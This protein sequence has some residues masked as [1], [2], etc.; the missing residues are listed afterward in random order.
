ML[1]APLSLALRDAFQR[2]LQDP[3]ELMLKNIRV[4]EG[5]QALVL[6]ITLQPLLAPAG[7]RGCVLVVFFEQPMPRRKSAAATPDIATDGLAQSL[8]EARA[9]REAMEQTQE[10]LTASLEELQST[11]EELQSTNEELTT[12]REEMQSMNE[13]LQTLNHELQARVC[14]LSRTSNDLSNLLESADMATLFLDE[15]LQVRR[16]SAQTSRLIQLLPGDVGRPVSD[17][18][19]QLNYPEMAGD[20]REVLQTLVWRER[21]VPT[22]DGRCFK[23]RLMPYRTQDKRI[24]GLVI[25]F[26]E[27]TER[28]QLAQALSV[29]EGRLALL[30]SSA[31][32]QEVTHGLP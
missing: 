6:N 20:A 32:A 30:L 27:V 21:E 12:S 29:A 2:L 24:D 17:L 11:N 5:R 18:V 28:L 23:V 9:S 13:E 31:G 22:H 3:Q 25:T 7:L 16:F 10:E 8:Q 4:G 19:S 1:P 26:V 14:A 15:A